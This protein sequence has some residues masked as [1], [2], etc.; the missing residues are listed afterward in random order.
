MK[1]NWKINTGIGILVFLL[2]AYFI[3][4]PTE[5]G[6]TYVVNTKLLSILIFYNPWILIAYILIALFFLFLGLKSKIKVI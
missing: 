2:V 3:K 5:K 1:L 6:I 4:I